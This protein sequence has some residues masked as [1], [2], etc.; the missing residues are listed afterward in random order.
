MSS[1]SANPPNAVASLGLDNVFVELLIRPVDGEL[2]QYNEYT[3]KYLRDLIGS[4]NAEDADDAIEAAT[5]LEWSAHK[6]L[7]DH[8]VV[9]GYS[10]GGGFGE[11]I[12]KLFATG[13]AAV[14]HAVAAA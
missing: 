1:V 12:E 7:T 8:N 5:D 9:G 13:Y 3:G 4:E 2:V 10:V 6:A 11:A 14:P